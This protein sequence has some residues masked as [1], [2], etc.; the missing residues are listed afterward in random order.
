[1]RRREE[2]RTAVPQGGVESR[3]GRKEC[4]DDGRD[5]PVASGH[6]A[7]EREQTDERVNEH[8]KRSRDMQVG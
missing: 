7:E 4:C 8:A 5:D 3:A 6:K 1:M 2:E